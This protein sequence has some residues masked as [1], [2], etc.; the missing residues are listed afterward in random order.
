MRRPISALTGFLVL[1][2]IIVV[3]C[4]L[5]RWNLLFILLALAPCFGG[6]PF[7]GLALLDHR[8]ID[9][10]L[11]LGGFRQYQRFL[12]IFWLGYFTL[13][14]LAA[15]LLI[16]L[17]I[18]RHVTGDAIDPW[19]IGSGIAA[20]LA[21][22]LVVMHRYVFVF[23]LAADQPP[24]VPVAEL[25]DRSAAWVARRPVTTTV[26]TLLLAVLLV[27]GPIGLGALAA[28]YRAAASAA[29]RS[30]ASS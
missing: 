4:V 5:P 10:R 13:V 20:A 1:T 17:W 23:W 27:L 30:A 24:E 25:V 3:G 8:P 14:F 29:A 2:A 22:Q 16:A 19:V 21:L 7:L 9:P 28:Y 18:A 6:F 15:P 26:E 12:S 11:L